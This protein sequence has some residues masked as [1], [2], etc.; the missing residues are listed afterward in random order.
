MVNPAKNAV[1]FFEKRGHGHMNATNIIATGSQL[2]A[3]NWL[4]Q[5]AAASSRFNSDMYYDRVRLLLIE[6]QGLRDPY[7]NVLHLP[8]STQ[9]SKIVGWYKKEGK[10]T[11]G[12]IV[13][14]T[15]IEDVDLT[16]PVTGLSSLSNEIFDGIVDD[17]V[18]R[19]I[20]EQQEFE[21]NLK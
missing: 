9:S 18:K 20:I 10:P 21:K 6:R 11:E 17:D 7:T 2:S 3:T 5:H 15:V 13:Y 4:Y 8:E 16:K 19:A 1:E 14:E 12:N